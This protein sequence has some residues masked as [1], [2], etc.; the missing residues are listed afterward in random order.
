M[1]KVIS[2]IFVICMCVS[3][4]VFAATTAV[5]INTAS[6]DVLAKELTGVGLKKAQKIVAYRNANG[7]FAEVKDLAKVKG[8]GK[9]ILEINRS[10][11]IIAVPE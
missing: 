7:Q 11:I 6:A 3:G 10:K 1:K 5:N 2:L 8:I 4:F 9:K